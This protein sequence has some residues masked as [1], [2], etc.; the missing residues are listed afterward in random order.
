MNTLV[1]HIGVP[2]I[3]LLCLIWVYYHFKYF[4]PQA[5]RKEIIKKKSNVATENI[6]ELED[7]FADVSQESEKKDAP[8]EKPPL[9]VRIYIAITSLIKKLSSS[10]LYVSSFLI[11][12]LLIM[13]ECII[14]GY[15]LTLTSN[16]YVSSLE[17]FYIAI[18]LFFFFP[19]FILFGIPIISENK[20]H[21]SRMFYIPLI[22]IAFPLFITM[23]LGK[24]LKGTTDLQAVGYY[25]TYTPSAL[26]AFW[27]TLYYLGIKRRKTKYALIPIIFA[28]FMIPLIYLQPIIS[29]NG[30]QSNSLPQGFSIFLLAYFN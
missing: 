10:V 7:R 15:L 23:P 26:I 20:D 25:F 2:F 18:F 17:S 22:S 6:K 9:K 19:V 27:L 29:H 24:Y 12:T 30:Y 5:K 13:T 3:I 4:V 14:L 11:G 8:E 16:T 21:F 28:C 1:M